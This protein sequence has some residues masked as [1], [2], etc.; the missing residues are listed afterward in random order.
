ML[1]YGKKD[2]LTILIS[3]SNTALCKQN[4]KFCAQGTVAFFV[5][6]AI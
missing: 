5:T 6:I 2:S 3:N 1:I 4:Y